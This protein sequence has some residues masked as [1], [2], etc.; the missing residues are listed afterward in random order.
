LWKENGIKLKGK[1]P[2]LLGKDKIVG[3]SLQL[4]IRERKNNT[5]PNETA[6]TKM[7]PISEITIIW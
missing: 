7:L 5:I 6:I 3:C 1:I 2:Q 4:I